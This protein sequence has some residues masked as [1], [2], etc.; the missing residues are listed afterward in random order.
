MSLDKFYTN[1][2]AVKL[3]MIELNKVVNID[4]YNTVI[5]P[6]AGNGAFIDFLPKDTIL[7][8]LE[9]ENSKITKQ[10]WLEYSVK[11]NEKTLVVGNPPFGTRSSLAKNFIKHS[12]AIGADV[13]A[14]IL[15][16]TFKKLTNQSKTL[17]PESWVLM[18]QYDLPRDSFS[19]EGSVYHVPCTFFVWGKIQD[20]P[21]VIN[22]RKVKIEDSS[23]FEF[24]TRGDSNADFCINGNNGKVKS[25]SEV[26]NSKAE[27][28]IKILKQNKELIKD[29]FSTLPFE[30]LSSVNGGVAWIGRQEILEAY[31][32][33]KS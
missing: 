20:F 14:F 9:P 3:C 22:L 17:F 11:H 23:D 30:W 24:L 6:S 19:I 18:S 16:E 31:A 1:E 27:H 5:E 7:L 2:S 15:P 13:I 26:T 8:D 4:S 10:D 29:K 25:V 21:D 33:Q 28:Y 12:I 32:K